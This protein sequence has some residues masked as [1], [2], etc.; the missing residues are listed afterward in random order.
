MLWETGILVIF[1]ESNIYDIRQ[2]KNPL[3]AIWF[4][5]CINNPILPQCQM[6]N[7]FKLNALEWK[8]MLY[9]KHIEHLGCLH[10]APFIDV[11]DILL[12]F[13]GCKDTEIF[14]SNKD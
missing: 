14:F 3:P 10:L 2:E 12:L 13:H 6:L 5:A 11:Y 8:P 9:A 1:G 7:A 4:Q